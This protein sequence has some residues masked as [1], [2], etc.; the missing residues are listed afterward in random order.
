VVTRGNVAIYCYNAL[1]AKTWDVTESTN[2]QLTSSKTS[3]TILAKYFS[4]FVNDNGEMK[5]V[6]DARV[7][8][9]GATT[10][11]I[12]SNQVKI[13]GGDIASF[14]DAE[15]APKK[16]K[17]EVT[18]NAT[19]VV[20]ATEEDEEDVVVE[21]VVAY[22]PAEVANIANLA[23]KTVDVIFGKDNEVAYLVVT[24]DTLDAAYVTAFDADDEEIE[25]DGTVYDI[26]DNVVVRVFNYTIGAG[27]ATID[28]LLTDADDG[29]NIANPS[30]Y[31][32]RNVIAE[33]TLNADDEIETINFKFS[34]DYTVEV[35]GADLVV[36][37]YIV[38]KISSKNVLT[39]AGGTMTENDLEDLEEDHEP[40]VI[41]N[42]EIATLE[43]I[44]V[45]DVITEV[46]YNDKVMTIIAV[47]NT[48]EGEVADYI[49]KTNVFEI[50][51]TEYVSIVE[52]LYNEDGEDDDY[53]TAADA[54][55]LF[56]LFE[57]EEVTAYL[58]MANEIVA[59][60]GESEATGTVLGIVTADAEIDDDD[61]VEFIKLRI[62]AEDGSEKKYSIYNKK[63][64]KDIQDSEEYEDNLFAEVT[65]AAEEYELAV[66][67]VVRFE[68]DSSR[69]IASDDIEIIADA[70]EYDFKSNT[71]VTATKVA[72]ADIGDL[73]VDVDGKTV[74][75]T[76]DSEDK[77]VRFSSATTVI[78]VTE[79]E[80]I[81]SWSVLTTEDP[82]DAFVTVE[83]DVWF[84]TKGSKIIYMIV[85]I[86]EDNYGASDEQYGILVDVNKDKDEDD[87]TIYVATV[88]VDGVEETYE[89]DESVRDLD[90][91]SFVSF[92]ISDGEFKDDPTVL[93]KFDFVD[94]V[95]DL[96]DTD[97]L[98]ASA[99][100]LE[101]YVNEAVDFVTFETTVE[102]IKV[103]SI[104]VVDGETY[105]VFDNEDTADL[106]DGYIVYNLADGEMADEVNKGDLVLVVDYDDDENGY[107]IVI[108]L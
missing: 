88:L 94:Y 18:Y 70:T 101:A 65:D 74:E 59:V 22:V 43:D 49:A 32:T 56:E 83:D 69:N 87:E 34:S 63:S 78:N 79:E 93:V 26:A 72:K 27:I 81:S 91:G 68:A 89:C 9:S 36:A 46:K 61:E 75:L 108:V 45:G 39:V 5:L 64:G 30:K 50:D 66:G 80:L 98:A 31:M 11:V 1:T 67:T 37:E 84:F 25:I 12:G 103:D 40:R 104:E 7:T 47:A 62:L 20:E 6:E 4:D 21:A 16:G 100:A 35:D 3:D 13:E 10:S 57:E 2:G 23:G 44:E 92:K 95:A 29:L 77:E 102:G 73:T 85:A 106:A 19:Y 90:E 105:L 17:E 60:I 14:I 58:N 76:I 53:E 41:R 24:D 55:A 99:E 86:N 42:G 97:P 48:V 33:T 82:S 38:E 96:D 71:G 51:G 15:K 52:P 107:N 8:V 28:T 54:D